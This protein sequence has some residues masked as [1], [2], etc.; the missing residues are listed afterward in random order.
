MSEV[1]DATQ[2]LIVT[3][4]GAYLLGNITVKSAVWVLKVLNTIYLAKWKGKVSLNRFRRICG[5]DFVFVNI[6]SEQGNILR[7][8]EREMKAHGILY[9]RLPDL[10]GGDGRTQYVIPPADMAKLKAFLLDHRNGKYGNIKAG[11]ISPADYANTGL[12]KE[13]KPTQELAELTQSALLELPEKKQKR[14]SGEL[15]SAEK[16]LQVPE[17]WDAVKKH[18]S[19]I[20]FGR[21]ISWI[22]GEPVKTHSK[23]GMYRIGNGE[24]AVIITKEDMIPERRNPVSGRISPARFAVYDAKEYR[25]IN[26]KNGE[27]HMR[28][29]KEVI[30]SMN[31]KETIESLQNEKVQPD[32]HMEKKG[33]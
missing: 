3:G 33:R 4:K 28:R 10:C 27:K 20:V 22:Q 11:P 16:V 13:G 29:G 7:G 32:W 25:I 14:E 26:L 12:T 17:V 23:W 24:E 9:S 30:L 31:Q 1:S 21:H 19:E 5:G 18:D 6:G 2:L 8:I 15:V